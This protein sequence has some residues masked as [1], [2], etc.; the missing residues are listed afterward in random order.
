MACEGFHALEQALTAAGDGVASP[1]MRLRAQG[2]AYVRFGVRNAARYAVM[3]GRGKVDAPGHAPDPELANAGRAAFETLLLTLRLC[4]EAG[5]L[6]ADSIEALALGAWAQVHG[7]TSLLIGGGLEGPLGE[8]PSEAAI[9]E[10]VMRVTWEGL[11]AQ[12]P[13]RDTSPPRRAAP[14]AHQ[15]PRG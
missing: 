7:L 3:F 14:R 6:R 1:V 9:T 13:S 2:A 12:A 4:R 5:L 8:A 15:R 10:L 11:H